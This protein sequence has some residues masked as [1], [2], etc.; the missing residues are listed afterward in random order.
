MGTPEVCRRC[1]LPPL[2]PPPLPGSASVLAHT[3]A[4]AT[5]RSKER[6]ELDRAR[7]AR[8]HKNFNLIQE[9]V[10]LWEEAR[11]QDITAEKRSKLVTAIMGK[12]QGRIAE[13]AGS[14]S[15]SRVI[16]TC[17]KHG[18]PAGA[19]A[20]L[21]GCGGAGLGVSCG[22]GSLHGGPGPAVDQLAA[23]S[24]PIHAD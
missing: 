17:A 14:H 24:A 12:I 6:K 7:K 18:T 2:L 4:C 1:R 22:A 9:V 10:Q 23:G 19:V 20:A 3:H 15:A 8:K 13:L 11:R 16:Q 21:K 5:P